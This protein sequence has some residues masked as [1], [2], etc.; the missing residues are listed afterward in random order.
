MH[1]QVKLELIISNIVDIL[2]NHN[3]DWM[4]VRLLNG[5]KFYIY[6]VNKEYGEGNY[7]INIRFNPKKFHI[8]YCNS[9]FTIDYYHPHKSLIGQIKSLK[10][11]IGRIDMFKKVI[12]QWKW[13]LV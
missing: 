1:I 3:H 4:Y 5:N 12:N 9:D 2:I 6:K 10:I 13:D 11:L 8:P 7:V